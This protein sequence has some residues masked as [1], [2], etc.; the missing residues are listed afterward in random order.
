MA[1]MSSMDRQP[2]PQCDVESQRHGLSHL[3]RT[4]GT[5][6]SA[7]DRDPVRAGMDQAGNSRHRH[8]SDSENRKRVAEAAR[9]LDETYARAWP[10]RFRV[11]AK[12]VADDHV[13]DSV[14]LGSL[15]LDF[16]V[17]RATVRLTANSSRTQWAHP[18]RK[19]QTAAAFTGDIDIPVDHDGDSRARRLGDPAD[20]GEQT[21]PRQ[22]RLADLHDSNAPFDGL[23]HDVDEVAPTGTMPV[24]HQH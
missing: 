10:A 7:A 12:Y 19:M 6:E 4:L 13:V 14:V 20:Q 8:A 24:G 17:D 5:H 22:I 11:G 2:G 16:V 1:A 15:E 23:A 3:R 21:I 18:S 9:A